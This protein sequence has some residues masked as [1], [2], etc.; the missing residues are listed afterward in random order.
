[1][2][3]TAS[4]Q[5]RLL[6]LLV[7]ASGVG[8]VASALWPPWRER[9][10]MAQALMTV[11]GTRV[12]AGSALIIGIGLIVVGRGVA[13]RR[14]LAYHVTIGLLLLAALTHLTRG[15]DVEGAVATAVLAAVLWWRRGLFVVAM[16]P[17]RLGALARLAVVLIAIDIGY[18]MLGLLF[19]VRQIHPALTP[20]RAGKEVLADMAGL[21]GPL[22]MTGHFGRWYEASMTGLGAGTVAILLLV[23]LAPVAVRGGG[24][25]TERDE[26]RR[27]M[28][29]ADGDTLDPFILRRDKRWIFSERRNAVLGCRYVRGVGLAAGDPA[30]DPDEFP[31]ALRALLD[32]CERLGWRPALVGVR[33]DRLPVYQDPGLRTIYIGDEAVVD[34]ARFGLDGR[35]MRNVRQAVARSRRAGITTYLVRER[36]LTPGERDELLSL[37]REA[38]ASNREFGF[39]MALGDLFTGAFPDC[40]IIVAV[41]RDG[42]PMGFQRYAPCQAGRA[43]SLDAMR[44]LPHSPNGINE[45]MIV[46]LIAWAGGHGVDRVSLNFAAFRSLL[47]PD[48]ELPPGKATEAFFVQRLEGRFGIQLDSLRRFNAKFQPDWVPRYLV[49]RSRADLPAI[50]LAALSSEGF[51]PFDRDREP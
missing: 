32:L 7:A 34:V 28:D 41:S 39:S 20:M 44:R 43:L 19:H 35:R 45:Q 10:R 51:L 6:G 25:P 29:R 47:D 24:S 8:T 27:V 49:Y 40:L 4:G 21:P 14:R 13:A 31:D 12:A 33:G 22:D 38:R 3:L 36:D 37:A 26:A 17:A 1:V 2:W 18:G 11:E 30:G 5:A 15:L 46:D 23:A 42:V 9:L 50:G 48:E 16:P